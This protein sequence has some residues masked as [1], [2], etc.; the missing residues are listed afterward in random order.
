MTH[1][2]I[3]EEHSHKS[4]VNKRCYYL[5]TKKIDE[6]FDDIVKYRNLEEVHI[7][8]SIPANGLLYVG[9][10]MADYKYDY[11]TFYIYNYSSDN[12]RYELGAILNS[13]LLEY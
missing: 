11:L 7:L 8:S 5:F 13:N 10:K 6:I 9:Q 2:V 12:N 3:L 4:L 1:Q